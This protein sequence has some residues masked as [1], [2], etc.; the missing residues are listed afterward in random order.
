MQFSSPKEEQLLME[1]F[2]RFK[3]SKAYM[4]PAPRNS[5]EFWEQYEWFSWKHYKIPLMVWTPHNLHAGTQPYVYSP[6]LLKSAET[7]EHYLQL[8]REKNDGNIKQPNLERKYAPGKYRGKHR[9]FVYK[10]FHFP[11]GTA[12]RER[13][14]I[15]QERLPPK[16]LS[17]KLLRRLD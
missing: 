9:S 2:S 1:F 16:Q 4:G 14:K 6:R 15:F 7:W 8:V 17:R 3:K 12:P 13:Y 11:R 10:G 5:V